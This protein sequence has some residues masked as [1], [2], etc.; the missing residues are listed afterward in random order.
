MASQLGAHRRPITLV[1]GQWSDL[2]LTELAAKAEQ[3]GYDGLELA[4]NERHLDVSQA[5]RSKEYCDELAATLARHHLRCF[6]IGGHGV[7]QAVCDP[8]DLRHRRLLPDEVW[9]DGDPAGVNR[10]AAD[11][12]KDIARVAARL[13]VTLVTGFTGS[14]IWHL[15]YSFPPNDWSVIRRGYEQF[16]ERWSPILDV[17]R[18]EGVKFALEV[19]PTEIAYDFVT[20]EEALAAVGHREEFGINFDPSHLRHQ[21]LDP[22]EYL[23][24]FASRLYHVH[25]KDVLV[26]M[27]GRRSILG[28]HLNF[29]DPRRGWDFVAPGHGSVD[30]E[31]IFRALNLVG[32]SGP[33]SAEWEDSGIDREWAAREA[34]AFIERM[35]FPPSSM[36]FDAKIGN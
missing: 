31:A 35:D 22:A 26:R 13:G 12:M 29:G 25:V 9:G 18:Q 6:A 2:P 21:G 4:C 28:S 14:P 11:K 17:F 16:A 19:H 5:L 7:G 36:V 24:T 1:T 10:R 3:W 15:L 30:F 27:D 32:Y 34:R 8:V 33:L 20:T 23:V